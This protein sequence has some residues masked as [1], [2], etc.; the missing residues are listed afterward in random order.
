[1][2]AGLCTIGYESIT[3]GAGRHNPSSSRVE[4]LRKETNTADILSLSLSLSLHTHTEGGRERERG[5]QK[6]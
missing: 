4:S 5:M 2:L 3:N 6:H 1:M